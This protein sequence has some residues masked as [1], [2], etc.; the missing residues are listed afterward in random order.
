MTFTPLPHQ[1]LAIDFLEANPITMLAMGC[2]LGKTSATL[3]FVSDMMLDGTS[4]GVL[5]V[6]PLRV[7]NM[8][9]P[10]EREKW[11]A[12][13]LQDIAGWDWLERSAQFYDLFRRLHSGE[14]PLLRSRGTR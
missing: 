14:L 9:W 1:R 5:V 13:M 6:A 12:A 2:G 7:V 10:A 3:K 8:T 4:K 11:S